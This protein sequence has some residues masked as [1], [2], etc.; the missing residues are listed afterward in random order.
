MQI[1]LIVKSLVALDMTF[2]V[3]RRKLKSDA[4][5]QL[6]NLF[7]AWILGLSSNLRAF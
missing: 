2:R 7:A 3:K 4:I 5:K 6:R 1:L